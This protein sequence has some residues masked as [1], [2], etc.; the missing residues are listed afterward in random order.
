MGHSE[1]AHSDV[2]NFA[3]ILL[4]LIL[5]RPVPRSITTLAQLLQF[6]E[7]QTPTIQV[8]YVL[9][10]HNYGG[11]LSTEM[12]CRFFTGTGFINVQ[13]GQPPFAAVDQALPR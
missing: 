2:F 11:S 13:P 10:F 7:E 9:Q 12:N 5:W 6:V 3:T 4:T 8:N 1:A